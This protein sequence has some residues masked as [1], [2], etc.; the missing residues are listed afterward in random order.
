[1]VPGKDLGAAVTRAKPV[2][3]T[4]SFLGPLVCT[5]GCAWWKIPMGNNW[6][7]PEAELLLH[8]RPWHRCCQGTCGKAALPCWLMCLE[9]RH[10]PSRAPSICSCPTGLWPSLPGSAPCGA[11]Q[12]HRESQPEFQPA[13][14]LTLLAFPRR[15][16]NGPGGF[17]VLKCPSNAK[18]CTF[19]WILN[20][21]LKVKP[22]P[23]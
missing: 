10:T 9:P 7:D 21:D 12:S 20:T 3:S 15:G 19:I 14:A 23:G 18:V 2:L 11:S 8:R 1:M 5:Q 22:V 17:I 4:Q 6:H 16:E 13:S